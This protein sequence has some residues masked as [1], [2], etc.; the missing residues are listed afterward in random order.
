MKPRSPPRLPLKTAAENSGTLSLT[1]KMTRGEA[2]ALGREKA[3]ET[4]LG[5]V[6]ASAKDEA[7][8]TAPVEGKASAKDEAP[9]RVWAAAQAKAA[10][11]TD[12]NPKV[13]LGELGLGWIV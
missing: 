5:E 11:Q 9:V 12:R 13:S 4:A 6:K 3:L 10:A 7:P 8:E 2:K 1:P